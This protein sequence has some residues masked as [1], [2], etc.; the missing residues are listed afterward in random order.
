VKW[1]EE[2]CTRAD[3]VHDENTSDSAAA[4]KWNT[5]EPVRR[6]GTSIL[7]MALKYVRILT[8]PNNLDHERSKE[9]SKTLSMKG[10]YLT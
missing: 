8:S 6:E 7:L 4:S 2:S 9:S 3:Q 10:Q 1:T 5:R